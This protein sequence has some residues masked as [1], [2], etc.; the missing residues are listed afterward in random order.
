MFLP[1]HWLTQSTMQITAL[2]LPVLYLVFGF[3][4]IV[5]DDYSDLFNYQLPAIIASIMALRRLAPKAYFAVPSTIL[6]T[7]QAFR[8]LPMLLK[9]LV[10][11]HGHKF[12]VTPKG[13]S[14]AGT[15]Y[16]ALTLWMC[17]LSLWGMTFGFFNLIWSGSLDGQTRDLL[18]V[19]TLWSVVNGL[20]LSAVLTIAFS[21][22]VVRKEERFV[23][24]T[25]AR[26]HTAEGPPRDVETMDVSMSGARIVGAQLSPNTWIALQIDT[27]PPVLAF[28]RWSSGT[29]SGLQF[30][31][32]DEQVRDKLIVRIFTLCDDTI[33]TEDTPSQF[34]SG[35]LASIFL[36]ARSV[37]GSATHEP[38]PEEAALTWYLDLVREAEGETDGQ[39]KDRVAVG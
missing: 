7:L 30:V 38:V 34:L 16:D 23:L 18:P 25:Q 3:I 22:Q 17:L 31:H 24:R 4:P 10:K 13:A 36:P 29:T 39:D 26:V 9:T 28:V 12:R 15:N 2:M 14:A 1:T 6:T 35:L 19:V 27:L 21:R 33:P 37:R 5:L 20:I 11:P 8:L 32:A